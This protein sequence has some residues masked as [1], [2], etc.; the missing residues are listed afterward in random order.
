MTS[1]STSWSTV[2][3]PTELATRVKEAWRWGCALPQL[4]QDAYLYACS[5]AFAALTAV[6]AVSADY[7][8]WGQMAA[9]AYGSAALLCAVAAA[10]QRRATERPS[11]RHL[12]LDN[13]RRAVL[14]SLVLGVVVAPL[15]AELAWRAAGDPGAHA[16][17]EVA[18]IERAGDRAAVPTSPYL[19]S[20]NNVGISPSSDNKRLDASSFFPYLPG[21]V[22]FGLPSAFS[23][24]AALGDARLPLVGFTLLVVALA[25]ATS[26]GALRRRARVLQ[27]LVVLP[28]GA[29]P[30]VTGGDDLPVLALTLFGL[31]LAARRQPVA[32]GLA[33]GLAATLK[34][35]AWPVLLLL[36][37][38]VRDPKDR[39]AAGRY[40]LAAGVVALPVILFGALTNPRGFFENVVRFPLGLAHVR[41]PAASPLLGQMLTN[42]F[43]S[44]RRVITA[45]LGLV[46]VAIVAVVLARR[47]P[48][49]PAAVAGFT[50]FALALATV[51]APATRFGYLIYPANLAVWALVLPSV[52]GQRRAQSASSTSNNRNESEL[53]PAGVSPLRAGVIE[54]LEPSTFTPTSQ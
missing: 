10:M 39:P 49:T 23:A 35:T 13:F 3:A 47:P 40:G 30:M 43:P 41:S 37:F 26:G 5:C 18:V 1:S 45:L 34:F 52:S 38:A 22:V 16:Q 14:L 21:M 6:F 29:L 2:A 53:E 44:E 9:L 4:T 24:S 27:F 20:P 31:V 15:G 51:L 42:L 33:L 36:L 28:F 32:A 11:R 19:T 25:L 8:A 12:N 50:A 7:R 46:G 17:P 48:R 54:G